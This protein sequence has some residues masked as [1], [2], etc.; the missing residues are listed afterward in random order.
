MVNYSKKKIDG[1]LNNG[2][3]ATTNIAKGQALENLIC[4]IIE[5]VP[6][7]LVT[8]RNELNAFNT[9]EIDIAYWNDKHPDGFYFLPHVFLAECKNWSN[10]VG[11][12]EVSYFT[13]RLSNRGL[14]YGILIAT[15]GITGN[16]QELS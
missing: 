11:S 13:S 14:D 10:P 15:N 5:K 16:P 8:K 9:E 1:Y 2:D 3:K 12:Q 4:Y 6:G 7:I